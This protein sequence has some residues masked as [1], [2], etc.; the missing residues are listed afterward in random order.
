MTRSP[1]PFT[2]RHRM[3]LSSL[4]LGIL[5]AFLDA[6]LD[7]LFFYEKTFPDILFYKVPAHEVYVRLLIVCTFAGFGVYADHL[8]DKRR[9]AQS[10]AEGLL[11]ER[12]ILLQEINHRVKNNLQIISGLVDLH[13]HQ[14]GQGPAKEALAQIKARCEAISEVYKQLFRESAQDVVYLDRYLAEFIPKLTTLYQE[15]NESVETVL[16]VEK[17]AV[18]MEKAVPFGLFIN[19]VVSNC[20]V[21]AFPDKREGLIRIRLRSAPDGGFRLTIHD[22][23]VGYSAENLAGRH[24]SLGFRLIQGLTRQLDGRIAF[25]NRDGAH[26]RLDASGKGEG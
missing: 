8:L 5:A 12:E 11:A 14:I 7:Y 3:L 17:V 13:R 26:V 2:V 21:H 23:G 10:R 20:L 6:V 16:D 19:E 15:G 22:N 1:A 25:E 4:T 9:Q 18:N 24:T